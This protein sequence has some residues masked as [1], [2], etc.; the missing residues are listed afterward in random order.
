[1]KWCVKP[2]APLGA[3]LELYQRVKRVLEMC[4]GYIVLLDMI[5][6]TR[7][8]WSCRGTLIHRLHAMAIEDEMGNQ[9]KKRA[10]VSI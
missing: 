1:M 10:E 3:T 5:L 2:W 4:R 6:I 9:P 7:L 8:F